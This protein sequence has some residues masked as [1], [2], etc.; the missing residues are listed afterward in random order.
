MTSSILDSR[1]HLTVASLKQ[2]R[3]AACPSPLCCWQLARLPACGEGSLGRPPDVLATHLHQGEAV[4]HPST[5]LALRSLLSEI[6]ID[7]LRLQTLWG[8][9]WFLPFPPPFTLTKNV[10]KTKGKHAHTHTHTN[11]RESFPPDSCFLRVV[12]FGIPTSQPESW[13]LQQ[14]VKSDI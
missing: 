13:S 7:S 12:I 14:S 1:P 10:S 5:I 11:T 3:L 6:T 9:G 4:S 8:A 2:M